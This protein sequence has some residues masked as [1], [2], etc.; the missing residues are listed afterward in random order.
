[1]PHNLGDL[2]AIHAG[3]VSRRRKLL[4]GKLASIA[5][6]RAR[7]IVDENVNTNILPTLSNELTSLYFFSS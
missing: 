6:K 4:Q 1:M 3:K 7:L 2:R 5:A